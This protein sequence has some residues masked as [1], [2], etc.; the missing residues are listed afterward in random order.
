MPT[1]IPGPVSEFD[2]LDE[3]VVLVV[4]QRIAYANA[5]AHRLFG[6]PMQGLVGLG[7]ERLVASERRGELRNLGEVLR[8]GS[9]RRVRSVLRREDGG[10]VDVSFEL[11]PHCDEAGAVVGVLVR[12]EVIAASGRMS[13][14][15][16]SSLRPFTSLSP[17]LNPSGAAAVPRQTLPGLLVGPKPRTRAESGVFVEAQGQGSEHAYETPTQT[18]TP[19]R[20]ASDKASDTASGTASDTAVRR[21]ADVPLEAPLHEVESSLGKLAEQLDWLEAR[22]AQPA[23]IAPLDESQERARVL[24]VLAEAR[25][26]LVRAQKELRASRVSFPPFPAPPRLPSL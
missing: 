24:L 22:F 3:P 21:L 5:A 1:S 23:S 6:L 14:A 19:E 18:P 15:P 7:V 8:G 13:V 20:E 2:V 26:N 17:S 11:A 25:E 10:R 9:A 4:T 12:Y 16:R